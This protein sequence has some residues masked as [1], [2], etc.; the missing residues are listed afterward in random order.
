MIMVQYLQYYFNRCDVVGLVGVAVLAPNVLQVIG[1]FSGRK[2]YRKKGRINETISNLSK[3]GLITFEIKNGKKFVRLTKR[4]L[5]Q[6]AKYQLGDLNIKRPK[7]WDKKWRMIVFDIKEKRRV[8]RDI[9][10]DTL[11]RLGFI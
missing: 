4:G 7:K 3:K 10:R 9:L 5:D 1:Q 6:L 2:K 8:T 11:N